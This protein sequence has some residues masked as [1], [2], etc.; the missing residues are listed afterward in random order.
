MILN[1]I[2]TPTFF[3]MRLSPAYGGVRDA[4]PWVLA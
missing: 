3:L 1:P 2:P 4:C